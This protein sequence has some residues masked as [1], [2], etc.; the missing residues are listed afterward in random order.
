M[1]RKVV[2]GLALSAGTLALG[3]SSAFALDCMN[4][5]RPPPPQPSSPLFDASSSGGP[6]IWVVQ[7]DWWFIGQDE[8]FADA[9][10]DK[11]PPGTA[12]S[13]LHLTPE[14]AA[15]LG[16]PAGTLNGNYQGGQGFGLLDNAQAPCV[17]NR[18][19]T[20]GIQADSLRCP[21]S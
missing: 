5:S 11:V 9:G 12:A 15:F 1:F 4:V 2:V 19:T 21:P 14:Q 17:A 16:L 3:T 13:V 18:Q 6:V 20:N 10:W 8:N 7:G